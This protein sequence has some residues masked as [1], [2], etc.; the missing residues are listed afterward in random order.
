MSG[1][2]PLWRKAAI[3]LAVIVTLASVIWA[4]CLSLFHWSLAW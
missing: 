4:L 2:E 3:I 1:Q